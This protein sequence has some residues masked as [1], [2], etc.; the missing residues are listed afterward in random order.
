MVDQ[1]VKHGSIYLGHPGVDRSVIFLC[2]EE[3]S[4]YITL[5]N[6]EPS[7]DMKMHEY[8]INF[9]A[10]SIRSTMAYVLKFEVSG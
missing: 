6:E 1:L 4:W 10:P 9:Q 2:M 8:H 3:T 5:V 7:N